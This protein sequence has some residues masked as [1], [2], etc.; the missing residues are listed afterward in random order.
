MAINPI[1]GVYIPI[2][3]IPYYRWDEFIPNIRSWSTL[4]L[5]FNSLE[6][7]RKRSHRQVLW[8]CGQWQAA[9]L[10]YCCSRHP[11]TILRKQEKWWYVK[12]YGWNVY[13]VIEGY[14]L[15]KSHKL[16]PDKLASIECVYTI[17]LTYCGQR[18]S[19]RRCVGYTTHI[20][21]VWYIRL[22]LTYVHDRCR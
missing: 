3:R 8:Y 6:L 1:V 7:S 18:N 16:E 19:E 22:H 13:P 2:V 17:T 10:G 14:E 11:P 9:C 4:I 15:Y 12:S 20:I 5:W 21:H